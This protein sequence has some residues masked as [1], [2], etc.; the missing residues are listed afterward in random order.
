MPRSYPKIWFLRHGQTEWNLAYRLQGQLNSPLTAQGIKDAQAQSRIMP[1]ILAE[2][3]DVYVSPLG[4]TTETANIALNGT[5]YITDPRL[6]EIH[7]GDW[8]GHLRA[9]VLV[10]NPELA[11]ANATPL[12]IYDAAPNGEGVS[13]LT[14][15]ITDFLSGL[16][17][18]T[19]IV[20]H[21][22]MGQVLRGYICGLPK[23]QWG[24]LSNHQ[25]CVYVLENGAETILTEHA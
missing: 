15:R 2:R 16:K 9:D 6:M 3:P 11:A 25:G 21:G 1:A 4:R 24:H 10:Q 22:L 20:A 7:A 13:A 14:N 19:V 18:P 8:Q 5:A 23:A 17:N 12:E